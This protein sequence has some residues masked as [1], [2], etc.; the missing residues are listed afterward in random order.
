M[1]VSTQVSSAVG[2]LL[3]PHSTDGRKGRVLQVHSVLGRSVN[4]AF[5]AVQLR[6]SGDLP[7]M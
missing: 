4:K 3:G 1:Q 2:T 6:L 5:L 7:R